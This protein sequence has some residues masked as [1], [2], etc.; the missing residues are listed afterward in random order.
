VNLESLENKSSSAHVAAKAD[1]LIRRMYQHILHDNCAHCKNI[2]SNNK[3]DK[4]D[5]PAHPPS[6]PALRTTEGATHHNL[7]QFGVLQNV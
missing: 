1:Y 4:E 6:K 2:L 7:G 3:E 5:G